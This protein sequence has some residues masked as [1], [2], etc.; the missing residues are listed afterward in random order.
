VRVVVEVGEVVDMTPI[1]TPARA[2]VNQVAEMTLQTQAV[3]I[4]IQTDTENK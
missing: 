2:G 1:T 4:T 3:L